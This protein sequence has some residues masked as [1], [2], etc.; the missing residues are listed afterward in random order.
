MEYKK[1]QKSDLKRWS[2]TLFNLGLAIS[3][4]T[5]LVAFEWKA[6]DQAI[7]KT[8]NGMEDDW[9]VL[10]I[11]ITIL[12]PPPP[13]PPVPIEV[14]I[15]QDD[16]TI[17]KLTEITIDLNTSEKAVIPEVI[18]T[19]APIIETVDKIENF[20]DEQAMFKGGMDAW[21]AYLNINLK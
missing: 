20:V 4:G 2:V 15:K 12:T 14:V 21:N 16:I 19:T 3:L 1:S 11:P 6:Y 7:I 8:F 17:E 5:T 9:D 10:N 13:P 18:I